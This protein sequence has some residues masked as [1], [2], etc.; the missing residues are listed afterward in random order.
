[1]FVVDI[2]RSMGASA[3]PGG[4]T[5]L[6]RA[7]AAAVR[8]RS[9][10]PEVPSGVATLTDRALPNLLPVGDAATFDSTARSLELEQPPPQA[11]AGTATTFAPLADVATKGYFTP[12]VGHRLI[13]LLTDGESVPF[14]ANAVADAFHG[15]SLVMLRIG[16]ADERVYRQDGRP[17]VYRPSPARAASLDSLASATGGHVFGE[18]ATGPAAATA[19]TALGD[20]PTAVRGR[21]RRTTPLAP[22]IAAA[23]GAVLLVLLRRRTF[24]GGKIALRTRRA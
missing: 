7:R 12:R 5:R 10:L 18:H 1:M 2:S 17:E 13:V 4:E 22:W 3:R 8:L 9:E 23:A 11:S 15:A 6:A 24:P 14:D 19:R 16:G 20:G 21:E